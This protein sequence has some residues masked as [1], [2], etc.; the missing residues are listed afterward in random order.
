MGQA[1]DTEYRGMPI[2]RMDYVIQPREIRQQ[3]R[4]QF[5]LGIRQAFLKSLAAHHETALCA[6]GLRD[7]ISTPI[8]ERELDRAEA[9]CRRNGWERAPAKLPAER[10]WLA[11]HRSLFGPRPGGRVGV[12]CCGGVKGIRYGLRNFT[13]L[14]VREHLRSQL[15]QAG[16]EGELTPREVELVRFAAERSEQLQALADRSTNGSAT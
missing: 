16:H 10:A 12:V 15:D 4:E 5:N 6:A 9:R 7:L 13:A 2:R 3:R 8:R 14:S 1:D 11:E